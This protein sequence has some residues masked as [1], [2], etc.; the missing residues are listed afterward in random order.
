[1]RDSS[2]VAAHL[3]LAFTDAGGLSYSA[4]MLTFAPAATAFFEILRPRCAWVEAST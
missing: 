3:E 1:M 4:Q 2:R